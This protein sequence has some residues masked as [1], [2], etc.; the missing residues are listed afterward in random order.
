MSKKTVQRGTLYTVVCVD[1]DAPTRGSTEYGLINHWVQG[2]LKTEGGGID[3]LQTEPPLVPYAGPSL[4]RTGH[5]YVFLLYEQEAGI[6]PSL[7][8]QS[9]IQGVELVHR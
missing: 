3:V 4:K 8:Q 2:G 6:L 9:T 1:P 5:R 7:E